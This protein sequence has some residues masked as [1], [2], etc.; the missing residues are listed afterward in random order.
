M[1]RFAIAAFF[2]IAAQSAQAKTYWAQQMDDPQMRGMI[3][4]GQERMISRAY[5]R[6]FSKLKLSEAPAPDPIKTQLQALA[7]NPPKAPAGI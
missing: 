7:A 6:L 4:Q 1:K 5:E 2:V 3:K